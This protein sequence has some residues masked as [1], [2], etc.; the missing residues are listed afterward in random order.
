MPATRRPN[1][2]FYLLVMLV[3]L[4]VVAA[5]LSLALFGRSSTERLGDAR[6]TVRYAA[7][8]LFGTSVDRAIVSYQGL[9]LCFGR[10]TP[11]VASDG[12]TA[13]P[14]ELRTH[15]EGIDIGF[16]RGLRLEL[17]DTGDGSLSLAVAGDEA[18]TGALSVAVPVRV[19]GGLRTAGDEPMISWRRLGRSY[20]LS[21]PPE[22]RVDAG[23]RA[24]T[25]ALGF[26][27]GS[28]EIRFGPADGDA[29]DL[30]AALADRPG[31]TG[32]RNGVPGRGGRVHRRGLG[33][34]DPD[35]PLGGPDPLAGRR[36]ALR[37]QR[38]SRRRA[39]GREPRA[40]RV[41]RPAHARGRRARPGTAHG[42]G[43][44]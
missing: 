43:Q 16:E 17:R 26:G 32:R 36:R 20:Y 35:T 31:G 3:Y 18:P 27:A 24:I 8:P 44:P 4:A 6:V 30:S 22:S 13:A 23:A 1:R 15:G 40:G 12:G 19:P 39:P 37:V 41:P 25:L 7:L 34:L 2:R 38:G 10:S 21:L 5:L 29:R 42:A 28:R 33:R 11:I 9:R 14:R